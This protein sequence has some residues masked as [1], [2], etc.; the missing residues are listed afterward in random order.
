MDK[1]EGEF[2]TATDWYDFGL[3]AAE[4]FGAPLK[5]I[6][7]RSAL[8][9][10]V[11]SLGNLRESERFLIAGLLDENPEE[12]LVDPEEIEEFIHK[13]IS[14][15][16]AVTT[17]LSRN[18][19]MAV[20]L[21]TDIQ[22]ARTIEVV[23]G[24]KAKTND[25]VAQR[26]FIR[27]DLEGDVRVI[28]RSDAKLTYIVKGEKL[29]YRVQHWSMAGVT[30]WDIGYCESVERLP[31]I[32]PDDQIFA[33]GQRQIDVQL[34]PHI[35]K[36]IR[37]VRDRAAQWD[38]TF[39]IR[40]NKSALSSEL[41]T[42][43]EF[44]RITQQLDTVI[45][46]A[47]MCAVDVIEIDRGTNETTIIV[48][49]IN[50]PERAELAHYVNLSSPPEQLR[51]WFKLGAEAVTVDDEDNP[52]QDIYSFLEKRS[53]GTELP[54]SSWQFVK[55][56]ATPTGPMYHFR[57][58]GAT[59]LREGRVYLARNHGGT[60]AQIRRR[61]KAIEDLKLFEGLLRLLAAPDEVARSNSDDLPE[62]RASIDLDDS[63]L[64]ALR[65][66][67]QMQP[68]FAIQGP[69]GTGKTTLIKAF[70]DR[71]FNSDPSA[72]I[73]V[74]AHSHHT[75]DDVRSKLA[76][77]FLD[78]PNSYRP[79]VL[80]LGGEDG[81]I[82]GTESVT[83]AL[84]Q[85]LSDSELAKTAPEHL[86]DRLSEA[87]EDRM[88]RTTGSDVDVR[89]MQILVQDAANLTFS[90]LNSGELAE[91]AERG[92]RF[93]WSIIEEAGKA[94]GFDMATALQESHRLLLIGDHHQLPPFNVKR[95][96][97]LLGD[98]L[99]VKK[100]IQAGAPFA[101]SLID[102]ALVADDDERVPFTDRCEQWAGMVKLFETLFTKSARGGGEKIP[103]AVLTDQHRMHPHIADLVGRVFYPDKE[104]GTIIKSPR[105]TH[106]R[107]DNP[108]PYSIREGS[109]LPDRRIV[110]C[111]VPWERK[112]QFAEG[113][114]DGLF[115]STPEAALVVRVLEQLEPV[116]DKPCHV[117]ILSPYR[118]QLAAIRREIEKS[119]STGTLSHMFSGPFDLRQGKRMGA[120][121][122]EFQGSE[123]DVVVVS[124]VRNNALL[125]WKSVGFLKEKNRMNVL[126][127]RAKQKLVIVGSW[128]FFASRCDENTSDYDE[129]AYIGRLM[130][131]MARAEKAGT[132]SRV[133]ANS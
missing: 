47:Q 20:R 123:A 116:R 129:H 119:Y 64:A 53:I 55:S 69:P 58:Q 16:G 87:V 48:T 38:K 24:G 109:W 133:R 5:N 128:D 36:N 51:D 113:E 3:V 104:G 88:S 71:L 34:L 115:V 126:L 131:E 18:L 92:R 124:L 96:T 120:T 49:P 8:K 67:W 90:T 25:P 95:F 32:R 7:K 4:L 93:D 76:E 107:F 61:H 42:V 77:L 73:L 57:T 22:I 45:T 121:V 99:R 12:R 132:V 43:H 72:Q 31:R 94:H 29:E 33:L 106:E 112:E 83:D 114:I 97:D 60:I 17:S 2:S 98:S 35:R 26:D 39:P 65:R 81:D 62:A 102:P 52:R 14:D 86:R 84:L 19:V 40:S 82:D 44:F 21:G 27:K 63:K 89:T 15:L 125:P 11:A 54:S 85:Q 130:D 78:H 28:A 79:I 1:L 66:I 75:I 127:S 110:W 41:R 118:G 103:A 30:T 56:Q 9:G 111:D 68:S 23:S 50:E 105:E 13:I 10:I 80:R 117:Q 46:I 6:R 100:A 122:D 74:T 70:A 91:L 59:T 101:P 108:T 37:S